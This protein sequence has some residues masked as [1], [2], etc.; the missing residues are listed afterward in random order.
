MLKL[1]RGNILGVGCSELCLVQFWTIFRIYGL[2]KLHELLTRIVSNEPG[3]NKLH[4]MFFGHF[5]SEHRRDSMHELQQR[6][7]FS[8]NWCH[9]MLNLFKWHVFGGWGDGLLKLCGWPVRN[10]KL[11]KLPRG[12]LLGFG[13]N[14][15]CLV[16]RW[17]IFRIFWYI[18]MFELCFD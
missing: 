6:V 17:T 5:T 12:N 10:L 8:F 2:V 4:V 14:E 9:C 11:L 16:Q 15:L 3:P 18:K 7:I 1:F 13:C